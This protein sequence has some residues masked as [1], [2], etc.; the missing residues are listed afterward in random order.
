MEYEVRP[1][2]RKKLV[3]IAACVALVAIFASLIGLGLYGRQQD[4]KLANAKTAIKQSAATYN[5]ASQKPEDITASLGKLYQQIQSQTV[6]TNAPGQADFV[7]KSEDIRT[8]IAYLSE[9]ATYS[10][11]VG[12]LLTGQQFGGKF[13]SSDDALKQADKWQKFNDELKKAAQPV[14]VRKFN[15]VLVASTANQVVIAKKASDAYKANDE[16]ALK[17]QTKA[18]NDELAKMQA[19]YSDM[20][21]QIRANQNTISVLAGAL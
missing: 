19:V 10:N 6:H 20:Y 2:T 18:A 11:S 21:A 3:F 7:R 12:K 16:A 13:V 5:F 1:M 8:Q 17:E 4:K 15:D 14:Q 9:V